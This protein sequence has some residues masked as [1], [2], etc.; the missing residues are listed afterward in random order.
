M[1]SIPR[2]AGVDEAG[3]GALAGPVVAAAVVLATASRTRYP[4]SKKVTPTRRLALVGRLYAGEAVAIGI[5]WAMPAEI[6]KINILEA[7]MVAMQRALRQVSADAALIDGTRCPGGLLVEQ[8]VPKADDLFDC[9]GAASLVA[10]V[11]RD[12]WMTQLHEQYPQYGFAGHKGYGAATHMAAIDR[13]G[14]C[15]WHRFS[16]AP[17][18]QAGLF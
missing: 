7:T 3:R 10:K 6:D 12:R 8:A 9:V 2:I 16:F 14:G 5:G 13:F 18:K 1:N 11:F 4:D 17:L 15:L